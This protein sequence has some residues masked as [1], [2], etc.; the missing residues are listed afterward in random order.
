MNKILILKTRDSFQFPEQH[1]NAYIA[2][3]TYLSVINAFMLR[4]KKT[5][6]FIKRAISFLFHLLIPLIK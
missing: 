1:G 5:I 2:E 4:T 6:K 3:T